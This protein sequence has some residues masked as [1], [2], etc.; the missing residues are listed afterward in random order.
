M[1]KVVVTGLGLV[2]PFGLGVSKCF[3]GVTNGTSAVK[4]I[5]HDFLDASD[6]GTKI[7]A[8]V[9]NSFGENSCLSEKLSNKELRKMGRFIALGMIAAEEAILDS[10]WVADSN[11][12]Q[13]D[14]AVMVGSGIG[15]L[16]EIEENVH[17]LASK[18]ARRVSPFFIPAS[19]SNLLGGNI[20]VKY[21]F[22]GPNHSAVTACATGAHAISDAVRLIKAGEAKIA[23]AGGAEAA[24]C[25][26]GIAGF[27]ACRAL[28]TNNDS[29]ETAS[30]PWDKARDGFV[31]GEGAGVM[32]LED[33]EHA[34]KR[35]A[36]IYAEV[37][38]YGLSCDAYHL[39][40]P[41]EDGDGARR[42][43][44]AA[45]RMSG[46]AKEKIGYINAHATSTP[47]GDIAEINAMKTF[48]GDELSSI[49]ISSTKSSMGHL[50]G[51]AGSV[52]AII[53]IL[54]LKHSIIP[55]TINLD[56]PDDECLG[57]NLVPKTAQEKRFNY[58][59]SNSFGFGG[60]NISL[61]F[62]KI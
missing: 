50:L 9:P 21:C 61:I 52:E 37:V 28:S 8:P 12:K 6:L 4:L 40:A 48:F 45:F 14:T 59:L 33:Y 26:V 27:N 56:N 60:T 5:P 34:K 47:A 2:T 36:N 44:E 53:S 29:P 3:E 62:G 57:L 18:G 19:L 13:C 30:R 7:A 16:I 25:R 38:G 46:L 35:G 24:I 23:I 17:V 22:K 42:A 1:T 20:A 15:G 49:P 11:E 10:G 31:M 41:S 51:A 54:A 39:T 32:V 43:I 55:P 58:A